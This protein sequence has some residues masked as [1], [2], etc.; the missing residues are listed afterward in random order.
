MTQRPKIKR[1]F[2]RTCLRSCVPA[3]TLTFD[4]G[5]RRLHWCADHASDADPYRESSDQA[6]PI[7][8]D[9]PNPSVTG[10]CQVEVSFACVGSGIERL[11]PL[12]MLPKPTV[13]AKYAFICR[14]CYDSLADLYVRSV[15]Q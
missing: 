5:A 2:C 15:H 12:A 1:Q 6:A 8:T 9:F 4:D 7:I 3:A 13:S 14:V 11:N 10:P